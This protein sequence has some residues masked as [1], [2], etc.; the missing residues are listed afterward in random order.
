MSCGKDNISLLKGKLERD[1]SLLLLD[2]PLEDI[3]IDL[4]EGE[5]L[6]LTI[7]DFSSCSYDVKLI[8][9]LQERAIL[10]IYIASLC[11]NDS[12]KILKVDVNHQKKETTS[13]VSFNGVNLSSHPFK[14]LGSSYIEEN[15]LKSKTRQEGKITNLI[16]EAKSEVSP[17]LY[18]KNNDVEASHG[19]AL[20]A[21]N[22]DHLFYLTSRG[23]SLS[24][25]KKLITYG[26]LYPTILKL[27]DENLINLAKYRLEKENI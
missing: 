5:E 9:N 15:A 13:F 18:I 4:D 2:K 10:N 27:K 6:N 7:V 8:F 23:I 11:L 12:M 21:Y 22:E 20:G 24:E 19:A 3:S 14:F 25:A 1:T 26:S 17:A 16:K